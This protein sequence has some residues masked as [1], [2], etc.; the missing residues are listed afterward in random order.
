[1]HNWKR[2]SGDSVYYCLVE[3]V[4]HWWLHQYLL[5]NLWQSATKETCHTTLLA[6][7]ADESSQWYCRPT[8]VPTLLMVKRDATLL[9]HQLVLTILRHTAV[10]CV[11]PAILRCN[12]AVLRVLGS[13]SGGEMV[14]LDQ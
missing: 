1:H 8:L 7:G 4:D 6:L 12:A 3:V 10:L 2:I 5:F 9:R 14:W 13:D 11:D